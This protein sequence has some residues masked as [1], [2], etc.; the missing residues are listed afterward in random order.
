MTYVS[1]AGGYGLGKV[2]DVFNTLK[3]VNSG[4][5]NDIL[6]GSGR[7]RPD[8]SCLKLG[9]DLPVIKGD[10]IEWPNGSRLDLEEGTVTLADGTKATAHTELP[11]ADRAARQSS[12]PHREPAMAGGPSGGRSVD[13]ADGPSRTTPSGGG[14][15]ASGG[16][17]R[18]HGQTSSSRS[19]DASW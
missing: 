8:G 4:V 7:L 2:G 9:D 14:S 1:K 19:T 12:A 3:T 17:D 15:H 6:S 11:A 10:V 18:D 5:Y 16:A 13:H